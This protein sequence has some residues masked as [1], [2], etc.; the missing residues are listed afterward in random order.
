MASLVQWAVVT[1]LGSDGVGPRSVLLCCHH[2]VSPPIFATRDGAPYTLHWG[3]FACVLSH[4]FLFVLHFSCLFCLLRLLC[5]L[6]FLCFV[7]RV[8]C[9]P[10]LHS[11][12]S[13]VLTNRCSA[14]RVCGVWW[15]WWWRWCMMC[16]LR[17]ARFCMRGMYR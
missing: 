15:L 4:V 1:F 6:C 14:V 12:T 9:W 10:C 5:F 16:G 17:L 11:V 2:F 8:R 3:S 7:P 13:A